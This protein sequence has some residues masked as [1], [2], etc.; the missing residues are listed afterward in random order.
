MAKYRR[1]LKRRR[2][3]FKR[4]FRRSS[5]PG[6][7]YNS[8]VV[9]TAVNAVNCNSN[10]IISGYSNLGQLLNG[11]D[12]FGKIKTGYSMFRISFIKVSVGFTGVQG[13]YQG[14]SF[15]V[16]LF[17]GVKATDKNVEEILGAN[18]CGEFVPNAGTKKKCLQRFLKGGAN[19]G[20]GLPMSIAAFSAEPTLLT[21]QL[22]YASGP[23]ASSATNN[24][25]QVI[26]DY[27]IELYGS[28]V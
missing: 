25:A 18:N 7:R 24:I 28:L 1:W 8:K 9:C 4:R 2:A 17:P 20:Y 3:Y 14:N 19:Y 11:S 6:L 27:Y 12:L 13:N 16:A 5:A 15:W 22:S 26:V 10:G 21:G 23:M